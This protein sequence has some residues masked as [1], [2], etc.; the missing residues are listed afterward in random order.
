M[1]KHISIL[2]ILVSGIIH[3]QNN[4]VPNP[5][6]EEHTV[7]PT[8]QN[9][10][11]YIIQIKLSGWNDSS[12]FGTP[13]YYNICS[14][15]DSS[16]PWIDFPSYGVPKNSGGHQFPNSGNAYTGISSY[17]PPQNNWMEYLVSKLSSPLITRNKYIVSFHCSLA[18]T[19]RYATSKLGVLISKDL[20]VYNNSNLREYSPQILNNS[21]QNPLT[22]K[23]G[24]TLVQDTFEAIGG[25]RYLIIGNFFDA[26]HSDTIS[27]T[28]ADPNYFWSSYYYID[29]V[30]VI[31]LDTTI[32]INE[33]ELITFKIFPNP[34]QNS[35]TINNKASVSVSIYSLSGSLLL[36]QAI[37]KEEPIDIG[38]LPNGVYF[39]AVGNRRE[40]LVVCR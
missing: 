36:T 12:Y 30:S 27:L 25:E 2:G 7:C 32:G 6:F 35:I 16:Q 9:G 29:D 15:P 8:N 14:E 1:K 18:D 3:G 28:G 20:P 22:D 4:L 5:S 24:W 34:A 11:T 23:T 26:E 10:G 13:D 39:V 40:K 38:Q 21:E 37:K 17:Y 31:E 19:C 33:N